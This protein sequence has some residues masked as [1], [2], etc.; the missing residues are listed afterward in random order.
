MKLL[1]VDDHEVVRDGL[2]MILEQAYLIDAKKCASDG[3]EAIEL[4]EEFTPDLVLLD[5]S[6]PGGLDG[7]ET[8]KAMR[9]LLPDAK[10]VIFSMFDDIIFQKKA[11]GM[12]ADGFLIKQLKR[13]D[14]IQSLDQ[15]IAGQ[16]VFSR[17]VIQENGGVETE[18]L[19]LLELPITNREKEVF[20]LTVL[21]YSQK[22]ISE[23]LGISIK[24]V[25][26]YCQKIGEKLKTQKRFD[27]IEIAIKY[28][29]VSL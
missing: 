7:I 8:L 29:V 23:K 6:M 5:L 28:N 21:G 12:G 18:K 3:Y 14:L 1:I 9:K 10:I 2:L 13:D 27:W 16:K 22:E 25:E 4:V 19:D 24:T 20:T 17:L 15:I 11:Y 26:N